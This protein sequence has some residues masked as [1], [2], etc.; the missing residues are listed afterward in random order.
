M[1]FYGMRIFLSI[2]KITCAGT[3]MAQWLKACAVLEK[4]L[5]SVPKNLCGAARN[6]LELQSRSTNALF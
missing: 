5:S 6:C 4:D 3:E 1:H 2:K